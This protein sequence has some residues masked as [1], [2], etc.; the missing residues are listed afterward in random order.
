LRNCHLGLFDD[1]LDGQGCFAVVG[2][3]AGIGKTAFVQH[4]CRHGVGLVA[5]RL[6]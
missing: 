1:V 5:T 4:F 3:E 6:H 2:G